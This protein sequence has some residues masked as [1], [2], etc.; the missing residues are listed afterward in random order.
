MQAYPEK[1][2][3][4]HL[5]PGHKKVQIDFYRSPLVWH[6][7]SKSNLSK[8]ERMQER[9]LWFVYGDYKSSYEELLDH[10]KLQSLH[11]GRLRFLAPEV[12]KAA[13]GGAPA[14]VIFAISLFTEREFKYKLRRY[15]SLI[16]PPFN[17]IFY[18]KQST[19]Y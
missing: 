2:Q 19:R 5:A 13:H 16:M 14:F 17:T 3:A 18:G 7:Y 10:A 15:H 4:I 12:H 6:F 11:L 9:A 1:F 8:L